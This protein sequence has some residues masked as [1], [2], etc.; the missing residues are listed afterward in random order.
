ML[1]RVEPAWQ[2]SQD[3]HAR[4][5]RDPAAWRLLSLLTVSRLIAR[6]ALRR[7]ES[8][9]GHSRTDFPERDD[10]HFQRH[11]SEVFGS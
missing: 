1:A 6:A 2:E 5:V 8:R 10:I 4:G 7:E 9:G 11:I 3:D